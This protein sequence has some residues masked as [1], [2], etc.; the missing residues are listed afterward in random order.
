MLDGVR[1]AV[2]DIGCG[3]GRI[4]AALAESGLPSLGID[5][6][7]SALTTA[8][9]LGRDRAGAL[10]VRPAAGRG[11]WATVLLL[12]GNI[13]IGG[14]PIRL[15]RRL[16]ELLADDGTAVVE[17]DRRADRWCA[18]R[19]GSAVPTASP[20]RG[21][22]GPGSAS[23]RSTELAA[24]AGFGSCTLHTHG[25]RHVAPGSSPRGDP[26]DDPRRRHPGGDREGTRAGPGQDPAV[27]AVHPRAGGDDR[28]GRAARHARRGR[29]RVAGRRVVVLDGERPDWIDDGFEVLAQRGDGLDERLAA[30]FADLDGPTV[31]IGMDT[32]QV[33]AELLDRGR[34]ERCAR[35]GTDA[36]LG[37]A[38]DGGYWVI[39]LRHPTRRCS[40]GVPMSVAHTGAAQLDRLAELGLRDGDHGAGAHRRGHLRRGARGGPGGNRRPLRVQRADRRRGSAG[41]HGV[42]SGVRRTGARRAHCFATDP[43]PTS[44]LRSER[45]RPVSGILVDRAGPRRPRQV[46]TDH[47]PGPG[48]REGAMQPSGRRPE[49]TTRLHL[50]HVPVFV[51]ERSGAGDHPGDALELVPV[52]G[53]VLVVDVVERQAVQ[54]QCRDLL[55][56]LALGD[57]RSG[58]ELVQ[59]WSRPFVGSGGDSGGLAP[60]TGG[61]PCAVNHG[62]NRGAPDPGAGRPS[63]APLD[64][65]RGVPGVRRQVGR[66]HG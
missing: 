19:S 8:T 56:R 16:R 34:V 30:A 25:E 39:G 64:R 59:H 43:R 63:W 21:S 35:P 41:R 22:S 12:D 61:C 60:R 58:R 29:R 52:Q 36:V 40:S 17:L 38:N 28:R 18:T 57:R 62:G 32:P 13:G 45:T 66:D 51:G 5:V 37:P 65:E 55:E 14:D 26:T 47:H 53:L 7:P 6:S 2:L 49:S 44:G 11:R 20:G 4:A 54:P 10:G 31:V 3:P 9:S 33:T 24:A 46:G 50:G 1:P 15:L 48:A 23:T 27:P 42:R